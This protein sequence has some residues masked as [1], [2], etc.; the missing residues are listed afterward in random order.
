LLEHVQ[1]SNEAED[2]L[3]PRVRAQE[4]IRTF[5]LINRPIRKWAQLAPLPTRKDLARIAL[6]INFTAAALVIIWFEAFNVEV[7]AG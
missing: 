7:K 5:R 1:V 6:M 4:V 3:R 2:I